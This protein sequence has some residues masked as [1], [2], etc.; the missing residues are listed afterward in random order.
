MPLSTLVMG[1]P[2]NT[3]ATSLA[4]RLGNVQLHVC[5]RSLKYMNVILIHELPDGQYNKIVSLLQYQHV[6]KIMP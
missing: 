2:S 3:A 4:Q 1:D 6:A 5:H